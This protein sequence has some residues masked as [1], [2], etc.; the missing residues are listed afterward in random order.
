MTTVRQEDSKLVWW[1][2]EGELEKRVATV[3]FWL[4]SLLTEWRRWFW[5]GRKDELRSGTC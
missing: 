2:G 4:C 5:G 3:N 1:S